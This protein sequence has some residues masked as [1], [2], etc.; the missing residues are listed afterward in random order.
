MLKPTLII[1]D[2]KELST[3]YFEHR[4]DR[5]LVEVP[6]F[7]SGETFLINLTGSTQI[8][9]GNTTEMQNAIINHALPALKTELF[10]LAKHLLSKYKSGFIFKDQHDDSPASNILRQFAA[11]SPHSRKAARGYLLSL[12]ED[13]QNKAL[14]TLIDSITSVPHWPHQIDSFTFEAL[15]SQALP[16]LLLS[17]WDEISIYPLHRL[18][19]YLNR[20]AET[21]DKNIKRHYNDNPYLNEFNI[22]WLIFSGDHIHT[23]KRKISSGNRNFALATIRIGAKSK[24]WIPALPEGG[25]RLQGRVVLAPDVHEA[26]NHLYDPPVRSTVVNAWCRFTYLSSGWD[27]KNIPIELGILVKQA[28]PKASGRIGLPN[29]IKHINAINDI[30]YPADMSTAIRKDRTL[31]WF[32]KVRLYSNDLGDRVVAS[33][34]QLQNKGYMAFPLPRE[35]FDFIK[36]YHEDLHASDAHK[37]TNAVRFLKWAVEEKRAN[38]PFDI[39]PTDLTSPV[40]YDNNGLSFQEYINEKV[41]VKDKKYSNWSSVKKM[42]DLVCN[43]YALM[44]REITSPFKHLPDPK[45]SGKKKKARTYR[46]RISQPIIDKMIDILMAENKQGIPTYSWA[47]SISINAMGTKSNSRSDH[48]YDSKIEKDIFCPSR[49]AALSMLLLLPLRGVQVR[50]LDQ[51]LADDEIFD[52]EQLDFVN[53]QNKLRNFKNEFGYTHEEIVGIPTGVIQKSITQMDTN[54]DYSI[55]I[56][57][58]K[59]KLWEPSEHNGYHIPWPYKNPPKNTTEVRLN[60]PY[61][62]LFEQVRWMNDN[63]PNPMPLR[64]DHLASDANRLTDAGNVKANIPFIVPLFRDLNTPISYELNKKNIN[65]FAPISKSKLETLFN[66]L[67]AEAENQLRAEGHDI[68]LTKKNTKG[69]TVSLFDI[70]SLRVAGISSLIERGVPVHIVSEFVAGHLSIVMTLRYL[71]Q[72]TAQIKE[73]IIAANNNVSS[74]MEKL[75]DFSGDIHLIQPIATV[76]EDLILNRNVASF[77]PVDG[78]V[79]PLG[80]K[81]CD[82][83]QKGMIVEH[84]SNYRDEL[85]ME[86]QQVIGGCGNCRFWMTGPDFLGEQVLDLNRLMIQM[87][88]SAKEVVQLNN[89]IEDL[90]W[91]QEEVEDADTKKRIAIRLMNLKSNIAGKEQDILPF[92]TAWSN[93]YVAIQESLE[94]LD[95]ARQSGDNQLT[96]L[97]SDVQATLKSASEFELVRTTIEQA[98]ILPRSAVSI[99]ESPARMLRE[100][101]DAVLSNTGS[102]SLFASIIDKKL[103]TTGASRLANIIAEQLS[104]KD[105]DS[106]ISGGISSLAPELVAFVSKAAQSVSSQLEIENK[107]NQLLRHKKDVRVNR[108]QGGEV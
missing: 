95:K 17:N 50:W 97:S 45:F 63:S 4:L 19:N 96:L 28:I 56:N 91:E 14:T 54:D 73:K 98:R 1:K 27:T 101:M 64:F 33:S 108:L 52:I 21:V 41:K 107:K 82:G 72:E 29:L 78:G 49:A 76:E 30:N 102:K 20:I 6:I 89:T 68:T 38:S 43:R 25:S 62:V 16:A 5:H 48:Y 51:G 100:F 83:C 58:N 69:D 40:F 15:S 84:N 61:T 60:R 80:G 24:L 104:E 36:I 53:N 75:V 39:N 13:E 18:F 77:A 86:Y 44:G 79:C 31:R 10:A 103:A 66:E 90:E 35:W 92:M 42:Y 7:N 87:R 9:K 37:R 88:E 85:V 22:N 94:A 59:T 106:L 105:I 3:A 23:G 2:S 26:I 99:P 81:G 71:K 70:H 46:S 32:E 8:V 65:S 55:Y 67:S 34:D 11:L 74:G 12:E 47:E 93:K 57:S